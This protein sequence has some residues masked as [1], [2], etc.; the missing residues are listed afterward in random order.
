[1]LQFDRRR[2]AA[3]FD[4]F[5]EHILQDVIGIGGTAHAAANEI[6]EFQLLALDGVGDALL[7]RAAVDEDVG[8]FMSW[9]TFQHRKYCGAI[10]L[11]FAP[12]TLA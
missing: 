1:M 2:Q 5:L 6:A 10:R 11:Y 9:K 7:L 12:A 3:R 4:E 8:G